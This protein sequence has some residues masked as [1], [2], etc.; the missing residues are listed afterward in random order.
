M[1]AKESLRLHRCKG[2]FQVGLSNEGFGTGR[3][4]LRPGNPH[5]FE[6]VPPMLRQGF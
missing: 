3:G 1:E 4:R 5:E 6:P 2:I